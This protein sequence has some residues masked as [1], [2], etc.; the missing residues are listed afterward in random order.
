LIAS[1][2]NATSMSFFLVRVSHFSRTLFHEKLENPAIG[3]VSA[4]P[5]YTPGFTKLLQLVETIRKNKQKLNSKI[6]ETRT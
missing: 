5:V 2:G 1:S 3:R 4:T 6:C